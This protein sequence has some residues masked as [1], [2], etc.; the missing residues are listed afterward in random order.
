MGFNRTGWSWDVVGRVQLP[1]SA[2][3]GLKVPAPGGY[4]REHTR[5][6]YTNI[7][8]WLDKNGNPYP[9]PRPE[10]QHNRKGHASAYRMSSQ[11]AFWWGKQEELSEVA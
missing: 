3:G 4:E 1:K 7:Y 6:I 11:Y 8:P 9:F 5:T 2:A 10:W